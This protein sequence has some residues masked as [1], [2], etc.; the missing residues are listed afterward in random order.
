MKGGSD[1]IELDGVVRN[2]KREEGELWGG[3][4]F[5]GNHIT[6]NQI[7]LHRINFRLRS[8]GT[9]GNF[10]LIDGPFRGQIQ[11]MAS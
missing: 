1:E 11:I 4:R 3:N 8:H 6:Q 7:L 5:Y 2:E 9:D 10:P